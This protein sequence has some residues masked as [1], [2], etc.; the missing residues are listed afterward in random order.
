MMGSRDPYVVLA[1]VKPDGSR[2]RVHQSPV[3]HGTRDPK[4]PASN[5]YLPLLCNSDPDQ[6]LV[7]EVWDFSKNGAHVLLGETSPVTVNELVDASET[8]ATFALHHPDKAGKKGY[9]DSGKLGVSSADAYTAPRVQ[10]YLQS[11]LRF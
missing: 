11:G 1:Q 9:T 4:W 10:E 5:L 3:L 7:A 8:H 2:V 6:P